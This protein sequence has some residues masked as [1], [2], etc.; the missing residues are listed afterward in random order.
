MKIFSRFAFF[1]SDIAVLAFMFLIADVILGTFAF[2]ADVCDELGLV[3][4]DDFVLDGSVSVDAL[5]ASVFGWGTIWSL[6]ALNTDLKG[7]RLITRH[8]IITRPPRI[9]T[10]QKHLDKDKAKANH[11]NVIIYILYN[12]IDGGSFEEAFGAGSGGR[13]CVWYTSWS[14]MRIIMIRLRMWICWPSRRVLVWKR[15]VFSSVLWGVKDWGHYATCWKTASVGSM[16]TM[17]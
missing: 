13:W 15:I 16:R 4:D 8:G 3:V 9:R 12:C 1:A 2:V 7:K 14:M 6:M 11:R 17:S 10:N 5:L